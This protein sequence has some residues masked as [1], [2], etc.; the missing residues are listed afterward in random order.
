MPDVLVVGDTGPIITGVIHKADDISDLEDLTAA[1][2]RF[3][4]RRASDR[5]LMIDRVAAIDVAASGEVHYS[6]QA[7]DTA[8]P[9][10]YVIEWQVTYPSGRK[11]TTATLHELTIRRR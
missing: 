3:Q 7:N 9:G 8:I 2:V 10:E 4:M 6:L 1:E 11:Q 5:R